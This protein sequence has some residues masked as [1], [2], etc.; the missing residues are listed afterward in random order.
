MRRYL[1]SVKYLGE[2]QKVDDKLPIANEYLLLSSSV[3]DGTVDVDVDEP[4]GLARYWCVI[5]N[6][7]V[8]ICHVFSENSVQCV[9]FNCSSRTN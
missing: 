5:I 7:L 3:K 8:S 6:G 1:G 9:C 2:V 4:G